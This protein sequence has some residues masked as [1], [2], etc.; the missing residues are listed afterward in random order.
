MSS[1]Y[2]FNSAD[3]QHRVELIP[4]GSLVKVRLSIRPGGY[5]DERQGLTGAYATRNQHTGSV[6]LNCEFVVV[7]GV[8][9]KRKLW[10]LI[11]LYSPKG[12]EWANRGRSLIKGMLNSAWGLYPQD[13]T[14]A[15]RKARCIQGFADLDGLEFVVRVD[16]QKDA[17]GEDQ[18]IVKTAITPEHQDYA[19]VMG[20]AP[21]GVAPSAFQSGS[22]PPG[23]AGSKSKR[24]S[25]AQ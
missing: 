23:S 10:S 9:A 1:W 3:D 14:E 8:Y 4:K 12:P 16:I 6:Y 5:D 25:W 2:D 19:V 24:P 17:H 7:D 15:A 21:S 22:N 20:V 11:G 13:Q 18:N